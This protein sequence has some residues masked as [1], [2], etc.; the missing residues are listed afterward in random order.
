MGSGGGDF[1]LSDPVQSFIRTARE[2]ILNPVGFFRSVPRQGSLVPPLAFALICSVIAGVLS[3]ILGFLIAVIA[4]NGIG[5]AVG[6]LFG[7]I[8][9]TPIATAIGLFIGSGIYH[10]LVILLVKPS[11]AG[12]QATFRVA[13]YASVLQLLSWLGA[14]PILGLLVLLAVTVYNVILTVIGI[15]EVHSTTTGRAAAVVLIPV[16]VFGI[17]ALIIGVALVAILAAA[18][19]QAQ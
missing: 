18:F 11:N 17:L 12:F 2:V 9:L 4:G 19:S 8:I 10:L 15:R 1:N 5:S 3:G 14:I 7:T 13:A 6:G 16:V